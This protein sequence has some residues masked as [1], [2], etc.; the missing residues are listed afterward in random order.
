[1]TEEEL[2]EQVARKACVLKSGQRLSKHGLDMIQYWDFAKA[3]HNLYKQAGYVQLDD[4]Q[5]LPECNIVELIDF[6]RHSF[7]YRDEPLQEYCPL[8][9]VG[10]K[11]VK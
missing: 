6:D 10:F 1:M 3:I 2:L 7:K 9:K 11:K 4:D 8:L 5:S